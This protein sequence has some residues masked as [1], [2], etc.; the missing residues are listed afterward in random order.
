[1]SFEAD[2]S[3]IYNSAEFAWSDLTAWSAYTNW[4]GYNSG[5]S[6]STTLAY[7]LPVADLGSKRPSITRTNHAAQGTGAWTWEVSDDNSTYTSDT[8]P[9]N[10]RYIRPTLTITNSSDVPALLGATVSFEDADTLL[11]QQ[12]NIDTSTL[13][14]SVGSRQ[15]APTKDFS[16]ILD[17][18]IRAA[19]TETKNIL[20]WATDMDTT[21][22]VIHIVDADT[23]G[24]IA[25]DATVN[26]HIH[27][28]PAFTT[29]ANGDIAPL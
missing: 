5:L 9:F 19:E 25:V 4:R 6:V 18:E 3:R 23:W 28:F 20:A 26:I 10:S 22:P 8:P 27:G 12:K 16:E 15:L 2:D 14:G 24:K 17:I 1:M 29:L 13:A 7:V 11:E 21:T